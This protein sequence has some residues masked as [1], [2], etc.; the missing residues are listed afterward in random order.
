MSGKNHDQNFYCDGFVMV[1]SPGKVCDV[2]L[3][4]SS[5]AGNLRLRGADIWDKNKEHLGYVVPENFAIETMRAAKNYLK[6]HRGRWVRVRGL[7]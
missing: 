3:Y 1:I 7:G 6:S 2:T 5:G 4:F